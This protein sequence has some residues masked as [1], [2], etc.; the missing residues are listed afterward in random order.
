MYLTLLGQSNST[1]LK[2][3]LALI[4]IEKI[5]S[6]FILIIFKIQD[7]LDKS[8][9]IRPSTMAVFALKCVVALSFELLL[10]VNTKA[11]SVLLKFTL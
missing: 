5:Y 8:L 3:G 6:S 4:C 10:D 2:S 9:S 11:I 1:T 7:M